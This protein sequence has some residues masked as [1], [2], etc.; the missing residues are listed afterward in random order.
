VI[1][2]MQ[3]GLMRTLPGFVGH[4]VADRKVIEGRKSFA[5]RLGEQAEDMFAV[6]L[7]A[8]QLQQHLDDWCAHVYGAKPHAGLKG[9]T[10]FAAAATAGGS[11]RRIEDPRALDMLLAPAAGKDG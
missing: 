9:L 5:A 1:G 10:P 4:S 3:R 6:E 7:T 11:V 8:A 2:T